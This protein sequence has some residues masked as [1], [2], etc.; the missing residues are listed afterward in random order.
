M[1]WKEILHNP[2]S[3]PSATMDEL[4]VM[5][6]KY[7]YF[8]TAHILLSRAKFLYEPAESGAGLKIAAAYSANRKKL[9]DLLH[10]TPSQLVTEHASAEEKPMPLAAQIEIPENPPEKAMVPTEAPVSDESG[11][12]SVSHIEEPSVITNL[13][14]EQPLDEKQI[15][16]SKIKEAAEEV[17]SEGVPTELD[18]EVMAT[19][20]SHY[21]ALHLEKELDQQ[22]VQPDSDSQPTE[23][24]TE[25]NF[26]D[27]LKNPQVAE[28]QDNKEEIKEKQAFKKPEDLLVEKFI[29]EEPKISKPKTE[30]YSPVNMARQSVTEDDNLASETL[31]KIYMAQGN[32]SKAI[33]TLRVLELKYPEKSLYFAALIQETRKKQQNKPTK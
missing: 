4:Y 11:Q 14:N 12:D 3:M 31:A 22:Q 8:A 7:P 25:K 20:I 26:F 5:T 24:G 32:Y 29:R 13:Q 21:T 23:K 16:H 15:E 9:Y 28:K 19:G 10:D 17:L 6:R 1:N 27:W 2:N 33:R 18:V 30:F